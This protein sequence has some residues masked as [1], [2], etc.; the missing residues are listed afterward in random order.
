MPKFDKT[1]ESPIR[2][3]YSVPPE[4]KADKTGFLPKRGVFPDKTDRRRGHLPKTG[5]EQEP[6]NEMAK[7]SSDQNKKA[8]PGGGKKESGEYYIYV[9]C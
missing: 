2:T 5:P 1:N 6:T 9:N 7:T 4:T 8:T 3:G